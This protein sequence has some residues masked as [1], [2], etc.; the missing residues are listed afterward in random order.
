MPV[1]R[2]EGRQLQDTSALPY[3]WNVQSGSLLPVHPP[4]VPPLAPHPVR[5]GIEETLNFNSMIDST[6]PGFGLYSYVDRPTSAAIA[7]RTDNSVPAL[8]VQ[9]L[10]MPGFPVGAY[11]PPAPGQ[12]TAIGSP[13]GLDRR[14]LYDTIAHYHNGLLT[15]PAHRRDYLSAHNINGE[16]DFL[17][18]AKAQGLTYNMGRICLPHPTHSSSQLLLS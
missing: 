14:H 3:I 11:V 1:G 13:A 17:S 7:L 12:K 9:S 18:L 8:P 4:P 15:T 6:H 2:Y 10:A 5:V 16:L